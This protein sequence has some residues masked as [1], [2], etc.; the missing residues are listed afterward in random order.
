VDHTVGA[1]EGLLARLDDTPW[2]HPPDSVDEAR[3]R[4]FE[5]QLAEGL[6]NDQRLAEIERALDA[7]DP[8]D[9][10]WE[11]AVLDEAHDVDATLREWEE[12]LRESPSPERAAGLQSRFERLQQ[13]LRE[14]RLAVEGAVSAL[15]NEYASIHTTQASSSSGPNWQQRL[16]AIREEQGLLLAQWRARL[17]ARLDDARRELDAM[18]SVDRLR[19]EDVEAELA[20]QIAL[21]ERELQSAGG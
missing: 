7:M 11:Q 5:R 8:T 21:L 20:R 9:A 17:E 15:A 6:V 14:E 16:R 19:D 2:A 10:D 18:R 1:A 3:L 4:E 13:E 12:L